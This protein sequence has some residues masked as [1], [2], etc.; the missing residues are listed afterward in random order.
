MGES[1]LSSSGDNDMAAEDE[2]G[3]KG[4]GEEHERDDD[5]GVGT[6][7]DDECVLG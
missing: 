2:R 1:R 5:E 4:E 3:D 6:G 7:L